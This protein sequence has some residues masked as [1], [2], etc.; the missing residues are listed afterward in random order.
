MKD[1]YDNIHVLKAA[2]KQTQFKANLSLRE[3]TQFWLAPSI[4]GG[5]EKTKPILPSRNKT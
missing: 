4:A 3:Q 1:I 5:F 2:K